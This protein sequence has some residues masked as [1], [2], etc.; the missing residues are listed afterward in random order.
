MFIKSS[1]CF[2]NGKSENYENPSIIFVKM[3][4]LV[5]IFEF[6]EVDISSFWIGLTINC[7]IVLD[8]PDYSTIITNKTP[9]PVTHN[10][11]NTKLYINPIFPNPKT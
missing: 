3:P 11:K 4:K 7:Y 10:H 8:L 5:E 1:I 6:R 9:N 2:Q